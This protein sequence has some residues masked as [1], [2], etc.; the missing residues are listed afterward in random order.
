MDLMSFFRRISY[1]L[2]ILGRRLGLE[3][4]SNIEPKDVKYWGYF[5]KDIAK[6]I[7]TFNSALLHFLRAKWGIYKG[8]NIILKYRSDPFNKPPKFPIEDLELSK[9]KILQFDK[10]IRN[11]IP[12]KYK[13]VKELKEEIDNE[14]KIKLIILEKTINLIEKIDWIIFYY[15]KNFNYLILDRALAERK[16]LISVL[17]ET[18]D[19]FNEI[20]SDLVNIYG[21]KRL[22]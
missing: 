6:E 18:R 21:K 17:R 7:L 15:S 11:Q 19:L 13:Q 22:F 4:K 2:E 9:K 16:M 12:N 5:E 1:E 10:L 20:F 14:T 8:T 3:E